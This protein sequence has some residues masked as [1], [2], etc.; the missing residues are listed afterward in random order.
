[1]TTTPSQKEKLLKMSSFKVTKPP[2]GETVTN[3][4]F[5]DHYTLPKL[6]MLQMSSFKSKT[7][8]P[9]VETVKNKFSRPKHTLPKYQLLKMSSFRTT[10]PSQ[11]INC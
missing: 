3:E 5:Q 6:K 7:H 9:K 2:K 10:T 4:F 1:M 11:S 8:P